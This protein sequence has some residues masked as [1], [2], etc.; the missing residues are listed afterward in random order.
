MNTLKLHTKTLVL[1]LERFGLNETSFGRLG[2]RKVQAYLHL[3]TFDVTAAVRKLRP[4]K[5]FRYMASRVDRWIE[6]LRRLHPQVSFRAKAAKFAG[7]GVRR[8]SELPSSL[9]VRGSAREIS[10]IAN[11]AG[12]R[13]IYVAKV[14]GRRHRPSPK[15]VLEW[16]CVRAFVVI[17]VE[18]AKSGQQHTEERFML[19]R[20]CSFEDAKKRLRQQWREYAT[21]Y[22]NSEGQMVSWQLDHVVDVYQTS[23]E[24]IDPAG[25]EVYSKL[26]KRRMRQKYIWRPGKNDP[27]SG[28]KP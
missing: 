7:D 6:S 16:Y 27:L 17:C 13:S 18:R 8:W 15:A 11:A 10:A 25:T 21:P 20:A 3:R 14:A 23:K 9:E 5:R 4:S 28:P 19:V 12:V 26:S 22:L 1:G 24:E 2:G